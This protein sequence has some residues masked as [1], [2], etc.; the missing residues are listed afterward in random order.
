VKPDEL[1]RVRLVVD[2]GVYVADDE[3]RWGNPDPKTFVMPVIVAVDSASWSVADF[4]C[5]GFV[6]GDDFDAFAAAFAAGDGAADV[7]RNG[8]VNGDDHD[9]FTE[10]FTGGSP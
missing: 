3:D 2:Y 10:A 6:N 7:D 1:G 8:F 9:V 4:D 5:D